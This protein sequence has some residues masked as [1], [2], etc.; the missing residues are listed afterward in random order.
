VGDIWYFDLRGPNKDIWVWVRIAPSGGV[1]ARCERT[2]NYYL[3]ALEDAQNHGLLGRPQFG[4]P[5]ASI[6]APR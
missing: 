2:F 6:I 1:V 4:P 5:P 3:E